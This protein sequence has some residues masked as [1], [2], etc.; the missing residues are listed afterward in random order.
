MNRASVFEWHKRF[1]EGRESGNLFNDP[2]ICMCIAVSIEQNSLLLMN[3]I[4]YTLMSSIT[5]VIHI[6]IQSNSNA[7]G[8]R[9]TL[10]FR[11]ERFY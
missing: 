5:N 10:L 11:Y 6:D 4:F 3:Y 9:R 2:R 8:S 7:G 1:K